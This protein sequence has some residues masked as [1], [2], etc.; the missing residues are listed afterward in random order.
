[1]QGPQVIRLMAIVA[2]AASLVGAGAGWK[3]QAWRLGSKIQSMQTEFTQTLAEA[4]RKAQEQ[5]R[6]LNTQIQEARNAAAKREQNYRRDGDALRAELDWLRVET[7]D[8]GRELPTLTPA[9]ASGRG[10]TALKLFEQCA[11]EYEKMARHAQGHANDTLML[12]EAWP[13]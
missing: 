6:R 4:E 1:M 13:K 11:I 8:A 12:Q 5:E 10:A 7:A 9:A 3:V 2:L